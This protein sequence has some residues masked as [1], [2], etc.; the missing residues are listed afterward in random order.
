MHLSGGLRVN[1]LQNLDTFEEIVLEPRLNFHAFLAPKFRVEVLGEFKNQVTHQ[2]IDLDENFLG[3][4]KRRWTL[5][6]ESTLPIT[7]SKQASLGFNY[8]KEN[9]YVGIEGFIKEV[10]GISTSTQ[11]F[12]NQNQFSGE[13]GKYDNKGVEFLVNHR[14]AHFS[15]WLSYTFND[16]N[17]TFDSIVP[18]SF[19]NNRDIKHAITAASTYAYGNLKV[20]LG[21]NYRTGRPFTEPLDPPD[22]LDT[23]VIPFRINY[24]TPNSRRLPDYMRLDASATYEFPLSRRLNASVGASLINIL[25]RENI[26]NISY[27]LDQQFNLE[28]VE[29]ISLGFTPNFSFRVRF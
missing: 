14:D 8:E 28:T 21:F 13:L 19:P 10:D 25:N 1:Y 16:N 20:S 9:W 23:S 4:E 24:K 12:Q 22:E 2:F 26:L 17:Y 11:G 29:S 18:P 7:K 5:S 27:R 6:D 15:T 3:I